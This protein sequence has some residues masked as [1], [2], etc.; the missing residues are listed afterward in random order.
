MIPGLEFIKRS[1]PVL[2][3]PVIPPSLPLGKKNRDMNDWKS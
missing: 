2:M 3:I 1:M